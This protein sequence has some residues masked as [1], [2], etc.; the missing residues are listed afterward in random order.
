MA[1]IGVTDTLGLDVVPE[2]LGVGGGID[3]VVEVGSDVG[4]GGGWGKEQV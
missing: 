4:S 2:V 3:V 1:L